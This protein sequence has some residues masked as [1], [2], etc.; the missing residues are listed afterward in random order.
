MDQTN[1]F[2]LTFIA[3]SLLLQLSAAASLK[4]KRDLFSFFDLPESE[5]RPYQPVDSSREDFPARST[6]P[7][8]DEFGE[9]IDAEV[10]NPNQQ[11]LGLGLNLPTQ[12]KAIK[13]DLDRIR[14][15]II[16]HQILSKLRMTNRPN[17][18]FPKVRL[19][20]PLEESEFEPHYQATS[21]KHGREIEDEDY[22]GK[23]TQVIIFANEVSG[24]C[25]NALNKPIGCF[26]F[27]LKDKLAGKHISSAKLWLYKLRDPGDMHNQ[28]IEVSEVTNP[29]SS[30]KK[31]GRSIG[32][33]DTHLKRGWMQF[34]FKST[35]YRWIQRPTRNRGIEVLCKTCRMDSEY[36]PVDTEGQYRPFIVVDTE[37]KSKRRVKRSVDCTPSSTVCCREQFYVSFEQLGWKD[38]VIRPTGYYANY[39]KGSCAEP[40]GLTH[41]HH[42]TMMHGVGVSGTVD[43]SVKADLT[44]CCSPKKMSSLSLLYY[45]GDN[46]ILQKNI[47]NM[48]VESCECS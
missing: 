7:V 46:Y 5:P 18:T 14:L 38:W 27:D 22:Y 2:L 11:N 4:T 32:T 29:N 19:P 21:S 34:D 9:A 33:T 12:S 15:E 3:F 28:T 10:A 47:P 43:P 1:K 40:T 36:S 37:N 16:K 31:S 44:P 39:C 48:I 45:H 41:F 17:T 26:H 24:N 8:N 35:I 6:G 20:T 30:T 25:Y 42:T 23:T 13:E